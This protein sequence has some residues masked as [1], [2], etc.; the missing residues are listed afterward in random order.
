MDHLRFSSSAGHCRLMKVRQKSRPD[1]SIKRH[2]EVGR[3]EIHISVV[4]G[5]EKTWDNGTIKQSVIEMC[6]TG[7][8]PEYQTEVDRGRRRHRNRRKNCLNR[9]VYRS[10]R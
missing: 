2:G 8:Q 7:L 1:S 9:T 6:Q 4:E 3:H 5:N 10:G